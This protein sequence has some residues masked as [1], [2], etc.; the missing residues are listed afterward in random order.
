[1]AGDVIA[2][3][4][5]EWTRAHGEWQAHHLWRVS[6]RRAWFLASGMWLELRGKGR[7]RCKEI[8]EE[9][10]L[11]QC[12]GVSKGFDELQGYFLIGSKRVWPASLF[13]EAWSI[14][15]GGVVRFGL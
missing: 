3:G 6:P 4:C 1:M 14:I 8:M 7:D 15:K 11:D 10:G 12:R 5:G 13:L 2:D 9:I